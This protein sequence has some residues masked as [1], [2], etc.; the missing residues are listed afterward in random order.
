MQIPID[1]EFRTLCEEILKEDHSLEEWREIE[2]D[3]MFQSPHYEGGFDATEDAFCFGYDDADGGELWF[4]LT[5]SEMRK[6]V[7]G[8]L[9]SIEAR[10]PEV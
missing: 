10:R 6:V 9:K 8:E 1:H 5:L 2:S 3:D 7:A 4:Q